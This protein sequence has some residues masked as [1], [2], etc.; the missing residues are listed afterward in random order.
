MRSAAMIGIQGGNFSKV[1]SLIRAILRPSSI[2]FAGSAGIPRP[3]GA[4]VAYATAHLKTEFLSH[5]R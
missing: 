4:K 2:V 3:V 1:H 5:S